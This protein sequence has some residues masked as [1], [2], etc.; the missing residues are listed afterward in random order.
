[1]KVVA[2]ALRYK[3]VVFRADPVVGAVLVADIKQTKKW[4]A[5]SGHLGHGSV[6]MP[7]QSVSVAIPDTDRGRPHRSTRERFPVP[8]WGGTK[9]RER[10]E[11]ERYR[12]K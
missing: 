12:G 8:R 11:E 2:A 4:Y 10:G 7:R 5:N 9:R 3:P 6:P 1:M